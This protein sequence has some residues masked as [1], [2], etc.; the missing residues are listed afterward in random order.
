MTN[1]ITEETIYVADELDDFD[2]VF[3]DFELDYLI[4]GEGY[5][6]QKYEQQMIVSFAVSLDGDPNDGK[7]FDRKLRIYKLTDELIF[8]HYDDSEAGEFV[9]IEWSIVKRLV[10]AE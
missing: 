4:L 8:Q 10:N 9:L 5:P 6:P 3:S 1:L 7:V 2:D